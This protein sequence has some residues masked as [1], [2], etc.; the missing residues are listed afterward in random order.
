MKKIISALMSIL[1]ICSML[2]LNG[3]TK[4]VSDYAMVISFNDA[5]YSGEF[6]GTVKGKFPA[7]GQIGKF[8]SGE[9]GSGKYFEYNGTWDDGKISGNGSLK[10]ENYKLTYDS[11]SLI[12]TYEGAVINGIP[13]GTGTFKANEPSDLV[14]EYNGNWKDGNISGTGKLKYNKYVVKYDSG[15][16]R[17]GTYE[18]DVNNGVPEGKGAYSTTND[19]NEK[20]TYSGAFANGKF[21]GYGEKSFKNG[22]HGVQIGNWKNNEFTP[23]LVEYIQELGTY[24]NQCEYT[25]SSKAK[26]FIK[27]NEA[28]FTKHKDSDI[29]KILNKNFD[30]KSF[31][32]NPSAYKPSLVSVSGLEVVQ[33]REYEGYNN[34]M[35]TFLLA[36]DSDYE[37]YYYIYKLG[38]TNNVVEDSQVEIEFM[39]LDYST[40]ETVSNSKQWAIAGFAA[41]IK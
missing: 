36:C 35:I 22:K 2:L 34:Q 3:C 23:S 12:G 39:P 40:Y 41:S 38:R 8:V 11:D 17:T 14:F 4:T 29:K 19:D 27:S 30:I 26:K 15:I 1:L 10:Q 24:K 32:K 9:E 20:Y 7:D 25:L 31:K 13:N 28:V 21:N 18:G 6:S 33:I 16:V 5:A 37:N